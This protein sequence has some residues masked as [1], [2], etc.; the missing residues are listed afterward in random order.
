MSAATVRRI[1]ANGLAIEFAELGAL[2]WEPTGAVVEEAALEE[3]ELWVLVVVE[4]LNGVLE[5]EVVGA[6]VVDGTEEV[7]DSVVVVLEVVV[8]LVVVAG[9]VVLVAAVEDGVAVAP[10][11]SWN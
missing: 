10:P 8:S 4:L 1:K 5:A 6:L 2:V 7:L 9:T 11:T 3:D